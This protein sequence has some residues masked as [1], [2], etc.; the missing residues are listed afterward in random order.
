MAGDALEPERL[1]HYAQ[2]LRIM[3]VR[4]G[5]V[6]HIMSGGFL[7]ELT[8]LKRSRPAKRLV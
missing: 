1:K 5:V 6:S 8:A 3:I 7:D 2:R 4:A